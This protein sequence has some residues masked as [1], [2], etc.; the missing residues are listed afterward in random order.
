MPSTTSVVDTAGAFDRI[1]REISACE[2]VGVDIEGNGL[3]VYR[4]RICTVQLAWQGDDGIHAAVIDALAVDPRVLKPLLESARPIKVIHDIAYDARMLHRAGVTLRQVHD[5]AL[6]ATFLGRRSTGLSALLQ[7]ELGISV[8]KGMQL[9]DWTR[10]PLDSEALAYL[11]A[12]VEHL[13]A[14][15]DRLWS[16][17]C[18]AGIDGEVTTETEHR[19]RSA[20]EP[21]RVASPAFVRIRGLERLD[22]PGRAV[23]MRA[24]QAREQLAQERD[25]P[26]F[27]VTSDAK[28]LAMAKSRPCTDEQV[29]ALIGSDDGVVQ[30]M[31]AAVREGVEAGKLDAQSEALLARPPFDR[32][33]VD[34]RKRREKRLTSWREA[35]AKRRGV[36]EQVVLP[37]HCLRRL[38]EG[39]ALTEERIAA[40]EGMGQARAARYAAALS[41]L[42]RKDASA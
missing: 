39:D 8:D 38:A 32:A 26:P 40:L 28:L 36:H 16:E 5:T 1:A 10:R 29:R 9:S 21:E 30:A 11:S 12:D 7:S 4:A 27:R 34:T 2:R 22:D 23:L 19:L 33:A 20:A 6:T 18:A 37:G 17:A 15:D 13:L 24:A 14:L 3:F 42:L 31:L 41:A 35:E 25:V